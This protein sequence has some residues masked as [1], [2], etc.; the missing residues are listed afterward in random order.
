MQIMT[1]AFP[2]LDVDVQLMILNE[3]W[4]T[5]YLY[6]FVYSDNG[7][8][9]SYTSSK[10][11]LN[12]ALS[13]RSLYR[14]S[15]SLIYRVIHFT[16]KR[17]RR[18]VN[19][20]LIKQLLADDELSAKVREIRILWAPSAN[21]Q[22]GEGSKQDLELLGQALP[23]LNGLKTFIWDAQYPILSWL[24]E[25]LQIQHPRCL[26]YIRHPASQDSAQTL[27][28]LCGSPCLFALDVTLI[29]GQFQAFRGIEKV[30]YSASNLRDLTV[31]S[32]GEGRL[33]VY[34]EQSESELFRLRSLEI[35]GPLFDTFK[36]PIVWPMLERLSLDRIPPFPSGI[37]DFSGLKSLKL[38]IHD[39]GDR[40]LLGTILQ[41][42]KRL[43]SLD[44]SGGIRDVAANDFWE[45][46]GKTLT[47]LRLHEEVVSC[48]IGE[49][50]LP[51][52]MGC[53]AGHCRNLRSLGLGLQCNGQE[54]VS[55]NLCVI[56]PSN[57]KLKI[58][59]AI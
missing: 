15:K 11:L 12:V 36:L 9:L 42:C 19:G 50:D 27:P 23:K 34:S 16:F 31:A 48:R 57:T 4:R 17:S 41:S 38:R 20:R 49:S 33:T 22:P 37:P 3:V 7:L 47:K 40:V 28:R 44:L 14:L 24:L 8:Q 32:A 30:L 25:A 55:L 43:E 45:S 53:I 5:L 51:Q 39:S 54:W 1:P 46:L 18:R 6:L 59:I 2:A 21:L 56:I 52:V 26:L 35:Y 10:S 13:S 58:H 29:K